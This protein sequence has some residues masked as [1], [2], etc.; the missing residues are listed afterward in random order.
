M[1]FLICRN[2]LCLDGGIDCGGN[3]RELESLILLTH[4]LGIILG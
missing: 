4:L 2:L 1:V 3:L